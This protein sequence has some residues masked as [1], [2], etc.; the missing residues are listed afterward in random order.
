MIAGLSGFRERRG[1]RGAR[2]RSG[3]ARARA[4]ADLRGRRRRPG[5][6]SPSRTPPTTRTGA[7]RTLSRAGSPPRGALDLAGAHLLD[8]SLEALSRDFT[9]HRTSWHTRFH[10]QLGTVGGRTRR[11]R[12]GLPRPAHV[13]GSADRHVRRARARPYAP[14]LGQRRAAHQRAS[15]SARVRPQGGGKRTQSRCSTVSSR[16]RPSSPA[17]ARSRQPGRCSTRL[18]TSRNG[19]SLQIARW[20]A[21][22]P[23]EDV[24]VELCRVHRGR[25]RHVK[26]A[27]RGSRRRAVARA[28]GGRRPM[29]ARR[30]VTTRSHSPRSRLAPRRCPLRS[31]GA[32]ARARRRSRPL[33]P[34]WPDPGLLSAPCVRR[35]G[36][37]RRGPA[38]TARGLGR[39][40]GDLLCAP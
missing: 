19:R 29:R 15:G 4:V 21:G 39:E 9:A 12:G 31:S 14:G 38:G 7:G 10:E 18:R 32:L 33:A 34:G 8:A 24:R 40:L 37:R 22:A 20:T 28:H 26:A 30:R 35:A 5:S 23:D 36:A 25:G 1:A 3:A 11:A 2:A 16:T 27:V 6:G 17:P 13:A